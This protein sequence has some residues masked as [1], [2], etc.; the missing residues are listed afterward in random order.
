MNT[1]TQPT[2]AEIVAE[3]RAE[4]DDT[5]TTGRFMRHAADRLEAL[6][7]LALAVTPYSDA[8][9]LYALGFDRDADWFEARERLVK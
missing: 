5:R 2:L 8:I 4:A 3:L 7:R 1:P 9:G 6:A